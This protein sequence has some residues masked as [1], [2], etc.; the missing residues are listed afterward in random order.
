MSENPGKRLVSWRQYVRIAGQGTALKL[1]SAT[2]G[3]IGLGAIAIS[4]F[5]LFFCA[6]MWVNWR[7]AQWDEDMV[8]VV[9][10]AG[11]G[12]LIFGAFGISAFWCGARAFREAKKMEADVMDFGI[13]QLVDGPHK[14]TVGY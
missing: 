4:L 1:S 14:G 9:R 2:L 13:V 10:G 8:D 5:S 6:A 3:S 7:N 12:S 11:Y